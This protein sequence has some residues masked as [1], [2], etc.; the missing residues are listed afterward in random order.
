MGEVYKARDTRLQRLVAIKVSREQFSERFEREAQ[1]VAALNHPNI[2]QLYDVGP[3]YLVMELVEGSPIAPVD[4]LRKL[5]QLATQIADGLSVAH[6]AGIVHRDLKPDNIL[7]TADGRVKILDFG[8]AKATMPE[9]P[10]QDVTRPATAV[11]VV[12]GTAAYMSPEQAKG[13]TVDA[14]S[15]QFSLGVILHELTT[16]R[17][18]FERASSA[19]TMTAIIRED[20]APLPGTVPT[21][22][23]WVIERCLAKE[24][25]ERYDSTGDLHRDL[26]QIR[27]RGTDSG[28]TV[29]AAPIPAR[30]RSRLLATAVVGI[31]AALAGFAA[32]AW[33]PLPPAEVPALIPFATESDVQ[34][35]PRWSPRGD[36]LAYV[37]AVEGVLQVFI[38]SLDSPPTQLTN[39]T[40]SAW[41]PLWSPD[42]TRIYFLSGVRPNTSVRSI[43]VAGGASQRVLDRVYKADLSPDGN[44]MAVLTTDDLGRYQLGFSSPPGAVP[45]PYTKVPFG[46]IA[47]TEVRFDTTGR[48]LGLGTGGR[49]YRIPVDGGDPIAQGNDTLVEGHFD[50]SSDRD[51]VVGDRAVGAADH[52]LTLT[53]LR[54]GRTRLITS[55]SSVESFPSLTP[56]GE[57]L[58][59]QSGELGF[60]VAEIP[61]DGGAP[62]DVIAT[63]RLDL[64]P[65]WA[66]DGIRF[67]YVSDRA[68]TPELWLRNRSDGSE[69]RIATVQQF[70]N[71]DRLFDS[72]VSPDGSRVAYRVQGAGG[73]TIWISPLSGDAPV[74]LWNDPS[75]SPQRGPSWSPDGNWIAY[76]GVHDNRFAVLKVRVDGS[77]PPEFVVHMARNHPPRW[78]PRGDLIAYRD[79]AM[80]RVVKPDGSE[81][82]LLSNRIWETYGWSSDGASLLGITYDEARRLQLR[83]VDLRGVE[84]VVAELGPVPPSFDM[85]D[86]LNEF[87]YRGFSLHPDGKS[88]LTSVL[89]MRMQ[90]YIMRGFN[91]SPRLIDS[92]VPF[93]GRERQ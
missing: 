77:A 58:A 30:R 51:W 26:R 49:F 40:Q 13:Q 39:E 7:I 84:T 41:G 14:R 44:T 85:A 74:R 2:C 21:A 91:R 79:G 50:W 81:S 65:S 25:G 15:D 72:A 11:G 70:P 61:L 55:G 68:G 73:P 33:W 23:R 35:M 45:T 67:V 69:R 82:R 46:D 75:N 87:A 80:M 22:L 36:R 4:H 64:A 31:A 53:D 93:L 12:M 48:Y 57:T 32:A 76:Y 63:S 43:A 56:D 28:P 37:A 19:E 52:H 34:A 10:D 90:I 20:A 78:S 66:P 54:T 17:R 1:A 86:S 92:L 6:A 3:N 16:G 62:R 83:R 27:D 29:P 89:K 8:L 38:K 60:D 59:F 42:A 9:Q 47:L 5:L 88:F 24:P 71:N 18:T